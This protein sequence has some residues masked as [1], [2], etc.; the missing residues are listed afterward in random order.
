LETLN[1][2][3]TGLSTLYNFRSD[4]ESALITRESTTFSTL[5]HGIN[6]GSK[7]K[8]GTILSKSNASTQG[9]G[10]EFLTKIDTNS[11]LCV[12]HPLNVLLPTRTEGY[13]IIHDEL[14]SLQKQA[15]IDLGK[16]VA[17]DLAIVVLLL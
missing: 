4:N 5:I 6:P 10:T 17:H 11:K 7:I 12:Y 9:I 13:W 8:F 16:F 14:E 1:S 3:G 2:F 15:I